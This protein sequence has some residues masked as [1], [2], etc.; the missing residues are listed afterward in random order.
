MARE[1]MKRQKEEA[2]NVSD[3]YDGSF[4]NSL[5]L[6]NPSTLPT[7]ALLSSNCTYKH[8]ICL[9]CMH[10]Q[11]VGI[12]SDHATKKVLNTESLLYGLVI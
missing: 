11:Y 12:A 4:P 8:Q 2:D 10:S 3:Q 5:P 1:A 7:Q 9:S 6:Q